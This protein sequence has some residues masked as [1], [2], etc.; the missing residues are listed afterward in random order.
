MVLACVP[1]FRYDRSWH[2]SAL[3]GSVLSALQ[4]SAAEVT[5]ATESWRISDAIRAKNWGKG[6]AGGKHHF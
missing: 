4:P 6:R 5:A 3:I 2:N 1:I